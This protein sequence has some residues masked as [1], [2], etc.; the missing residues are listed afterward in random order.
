MA[1]TIRVG[2]VG[3]GKISGIYLQNLTRRFPGVEVA[4]CADLV[5]ERAQAAAEEYGVPRACSPQELLADPDIQIV[6]NL[7]IPGAHSEVCLAALE[8]GK[9]VYVEKPLSVTRRQALQ[10][11]EAAG[12]KKLRL[13]GAPDTFLGAGMQTCR[14]LLDDGWIG[15][16]VGATAFMTTPGH[17]RWHPDPEFYYKP[18]GGPMLDM[19]PYYLTAL[20]SLLGPVSRVTGSARMTYR[21]RTITSEPKYG[22][23]ISVEV[24]THWAGVLDF[25]SGPIGMIMTS[26]DVWGANLPRIEVYGTAG[27]LLAPD[28]N[29]FGGP[30]RIL[31]KGDKEWRE[32]PLAYGYEEN[33][34]GLGVADMADAVRND[35]PHRASGALMFHVLDVMEGIYDA[36]IGG[37][38]YE[39]ASSCERPDPLPLDL[40]E[41][42]IS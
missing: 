36:A 25:A 42:K 26:F 18:G 33:N 11:V 15:V 28:P 6:V 27:T 39:V 13:G 2:L 21:E 3:C 12:K 5:A 23:K 8:A 10:V 32:V 17:E 35:R 1:D 9:H 31:R 29:T 40:T 41:G 4:A 14:K 16:P 24:P 34:R 30:I 19:G 38:H 22:Q 7:T 37:A 20:V